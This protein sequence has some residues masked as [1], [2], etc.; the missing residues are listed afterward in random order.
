MQILFVCTGNT[1]RSP[2]AAALGRHYAAQHGLEW[3]IDSAG[4]Y[5]LPGSPMTPDA[6]DALIR[7]H[8]IAHK[9]ESKPLTEEMVNHADFIFTMTASHKTDLLGQYP[10]AKGKT[11]TLGEYVSGGQWHSDVAD[12][13]GGSTE[14]YEACAREL[15][16]T[17]ARLIEKLK[18]QN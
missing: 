7:R 5:A 15:E 17:V 3:A 4:L 18:E 16:E 10:R 6:L 12:P 8:V 14:I 2:M 1:C 13:F 11:Y 9:H